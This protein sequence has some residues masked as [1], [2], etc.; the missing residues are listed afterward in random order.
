MK[1]QDQID[2]NKKSRK[3]ARSVGIFAFSEKFAI[4][5]DKNIINRYE[6]VSGNFIVNTCM[7][8]FYGS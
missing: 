3:V 5:N 2:D 1:S 4:S 7:W 8:R 6:E